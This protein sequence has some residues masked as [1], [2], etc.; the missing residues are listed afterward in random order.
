MSSSTRQ[1]P[2]IEINKTELKCIIIR[3]FGDQKLFC[4]QNRINHGTMRHYLSGRNMPK[5]DKRVAGILEKLG[6][7]PNGSIV[8][9]IPQIQPDTKLQIAA[10]HY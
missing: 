4:K 8:R 10:N 7:N 6:Y 5:I 2:E 9:D 1:A 3:H